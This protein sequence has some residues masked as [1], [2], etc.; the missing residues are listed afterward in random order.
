M[1]ASIRSGVT[2]YKDV[3]DQ[4]SPD[5]H[6][7]LILI[8]HKAPVIER[9]HMTSRRPHNETAAML[10]FQTNLVGVEIFFMQTL[11]TQ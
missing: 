5:E 9:F 7:S 10:V 11:S 6:V 8:C 3:S 4:S 1:A 2:D